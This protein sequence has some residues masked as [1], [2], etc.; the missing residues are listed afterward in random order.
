MTDLAGRG[1]RRAHRSTR[2]TLARLRWPAADFGAGTDLRSGLR[3][4][5]RKGS[6]LIVGAGCVLDRSMTIE[7]H[8]RLEIGAGTVF[9]HH[10]TVGAKESIVIGPDCLIADMV[11]I[12]DNDHVF[13]DPERPYLDQGHNT[14]PIVIGNNVWLGSRVI[15]ARGVTIG[16]GAVVGAGAVV[17]RDIPPRAVAAGVPARVIRQR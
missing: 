11:S 1:L 6:T 17:T 9:G 7:C 10:C 14:A 8:G 2:L 4:D 12:R 5:L 3:I 13:E 16:D 15:V